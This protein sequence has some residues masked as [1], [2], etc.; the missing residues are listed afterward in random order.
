MIMNNKQP[1]TTPG[2][3]IRKCFQQQPINLSSPARL[4]SGTLCRHRDLL[5]LLKAGRRIHGNERFR[6]PTDPADRDETRFFRGNPAQY[7]ELIELMSFPVRK[8][9]HMTEYLVFYGTVRFG[10]H[11]SYRAP[12][13]R[14]RL[15]AAFAI[16]FCY[17][18][19]D[20]FHQ[21]FVPD[22]AGRFTDVM[23]D[24]FL[25]LVITV[26]CFARHYRQ[27]RQEK[28]DSAR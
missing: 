17:A 10:L 27:N 23:I 2:I 5:V 25:V 24:C 22:R 18:C 15:F 6:E 19:T 7:A 11:F 16:V 14:H 20:E 13:L 9:A 3:F 4:D 28:S 12:Y 8:T 1:K 26:I 21:L